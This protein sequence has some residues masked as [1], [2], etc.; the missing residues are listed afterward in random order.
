[1]LRAF[2]VGCIILFFV[3]G[4][5]A[6]IPVVGKINDT[7]EEFIGSANPTKGLVTG[8]IYPSG[9]SCV[10]PYK[11]HLVWDANSTYTLDGTIKCDDGRSGKWTATGSNN[12]GRG[13]GT[14]GGKKMS[15]SFGNIGIINSY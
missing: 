12:I 5:S 8:K 3:S 15:I 6:P 4:C 11:T 2:V 13:I 7:E 10:A 9:I 1:M 14:L